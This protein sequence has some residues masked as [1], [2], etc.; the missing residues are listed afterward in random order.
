[1]NAFISACLLSRIH[2]C[3]LTCMQNFKLACLLVYMHV[4]LPAYTRSHAC[5]FTWLH[6]SMD[7]SFTCVHA[8]IAAYLPKYMLTCMYAY[9]Q[10]DLQATIQPYLQ[11]SSPACMLRTEDIANPLGFS[12]KR[13]LC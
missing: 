4:S 11:A 10:Q 6:T 3:L 5:E 9:M 2:A 12:N 7:K 1:M 13:N 8:Y